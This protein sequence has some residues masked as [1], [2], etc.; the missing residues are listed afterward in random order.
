MEIKLRE[1]D[2]K[3]EK[4]E[5]APIL[6]LF[7]LMLDEVNELLHALEHESSEA[8]QLEAADV[9][10]FAMLIH[11]RLAAGDTIETRN[12]ALFT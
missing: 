9:A 5:K 4:G 8:A 3:K 7:K 6:K 11:K 12:H 2:H 10:N 1:N